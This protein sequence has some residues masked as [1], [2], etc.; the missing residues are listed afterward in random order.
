MK[1]FLIYISC[2]LIAT[3]CFLGTGEFIARSVP[4]PYKY[5]EEW[6]QQHHN[7][8][9]TLVLGGSHTFYGI[10]PDLFEGISFNLANVTQLLQYDLYLLN[11]YECP[12]LKTVIIPI[13]YSTLFCGELE[14]GKEWYRAIF[15]KI[16]MDYPAHSDFSKYNFEFTSH[17]TFMGKIEKYFSKGVDVGYDAWGWG[18]TYSLSNK[19]MVSWQNGNEAREA[20]KR[21]TYSD[22]SNANVNYSRLVKIID[23]CKERNIKLVLITTPCCDAYNAMIDNDQYSRMMEIVRDVEQKY[24]VIYLDYLRDSR[25]GDDDFFDSNHLSVNGAAKFTSI[26]KEDIINT[27][28]SPWFVGQAAK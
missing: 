14:N 1:K 11:R 9:E 23:F 18:N 24:G 26:L 2:V 13:S 5:K 15:Y 6:M 7:E 28:E 19:N 8:V 20:I 16:Y 21:H 17:R 10:K 25:F 12:K 4:N 27:D 22:L 3:V